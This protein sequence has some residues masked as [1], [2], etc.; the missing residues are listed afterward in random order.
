[1]AKCICDGHE[2]TII[3]A[4][5]NQFSIRNN[6]GSVVAACSRDSQRYWYTAPVAAPEF[7]T[8]IHESVIGGDS[9][10]PAI[11]EQWAVQQYVAWAMDN[12]TVEEHS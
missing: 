10:F 2:Y 3:W 6:Y 8:S 4:D 9:G 5:S 12:D 11:V 1:M 7:S